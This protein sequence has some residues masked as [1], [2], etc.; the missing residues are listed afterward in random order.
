MIDNCFIRKYAAILV[1]SVSAV[2]FLPEALL[3]Q[4][5]VSA[6]AHGADYGIFSSNLNTFPSG[7]QLD[8]LTH[9]IAGD[10]GCSV[11]GALWIGKLPTIWNGTPPSLNNIWNGTPNTWIQDVVSR[12]H[13]K[14]VKASISLDGEEFASATNSTYL[15]TFVTSIV[16]FVTVH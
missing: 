9:V 4:G 5:T 10:I 12:A 6:F 14:D 16:S 8:R 1:L 7:A 3:A 11:N 2:L 13:A 15:T